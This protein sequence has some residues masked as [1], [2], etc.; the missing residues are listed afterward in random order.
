MPSWSFSTWP[1]QC[2]RRRL[3]T[4]VS[5]TRYQFACSLIEQYSNVVFFTEGPKRECAAAF[6]VE[7][8]SAA[9]CQ[10][11]VCVVGHKM[12]ARGLGRRLPAALARLQAQQGCNSTAPLLGAASSHT[13]EDQRVND[14]AAVALFPS[15]PLSRSSWHFS[16]G[17]SR[18]SFR[19]LFRLLLQ[20]L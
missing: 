16:R 8:F 1:D 5:I 15:V 10:L 4:R 2:F 7:S 20:F 12:L 19:A 14:G 3:S 18:S 13:K 11:W 17:E 9:D 6:E